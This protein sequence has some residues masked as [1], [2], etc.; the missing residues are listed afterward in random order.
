M[1]TRKKRKEKEKRKNREYRDGMPRAIV[2]TPRPFFARF[3][4]PVLPSRFRLRASPCEEIALLGEIHVVAVGGYLSGA[5]RAI[6]G[7]T[8]MYRAARTIGACEAPRLDVRVDGR[9]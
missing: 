2:E 8:I 7:F 3:N 1:A 5:A 9:C 6:I 4:R